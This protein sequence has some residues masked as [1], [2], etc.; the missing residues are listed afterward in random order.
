MYGKNGLKIWCVHITE[1]YSA[2]TTEEIL[3]L[4]LQGWI[5]GTYAKENKS[6]REIQVQL[7]CSVSPVDAFL[8]IRAVG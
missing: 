5:W 7:L 3:P 8:P 6:D 4:Q 2:L 1:Y